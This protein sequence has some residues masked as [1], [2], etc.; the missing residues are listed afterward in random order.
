MCIF[1]FDVEIG[2]DAH[3]YTEIETTLVIE[4]VHV[5]YVQMRIASEFVGK[6]KGMV[7]DV[8]VVDFC[9]TCPGQ[10]IGSIHSCILNYE[11][12]KAKK[13]ESKVVSKETEEIIN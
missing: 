2:L 10:L 6:F 1:R 11:Y 8:L 7:S 12:V 4:L 13:P 3:D 9:E 5:D